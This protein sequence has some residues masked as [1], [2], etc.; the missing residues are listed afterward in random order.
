MVLDGVGL[1]LESHAFGYLL[2]FMSLELFDLELTG[3][4]FMSLLILVLE[5]LG[6]G[7]FVLEFLK[8]F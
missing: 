8:R 6:F 5:F 4:R 7:V 1:K 2:E 3:L